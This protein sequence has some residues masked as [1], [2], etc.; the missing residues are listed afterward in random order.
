MRAAP[1]AERHNRGDPTVS[2][3]VRPLLQQPADGGSRGVEHR[4]HATRSTA[5]SST[6]WP[7]P[8]ACGCC[9]P[10]ARSSRAATS[11]TSTPTRRQKGFL[12]TLFTN[13]TLIT[14]RIADYLAVW[15]PFAIEITL[16]GRTKETYERLTGIPGSYEK[17][18]RGIDLLLERK[19]P[20]ALKTVAVTINM[21]ELHDMQAF[22]DEL[23][24]AFKFDGMMNPRDR[25]LAEPAR[26]PADA[27]GVRGA[28]SRGST[29][30]RRVEAHRQRSTT[31]PANPA[32]PRRRGLPLWRRRH[33]VCH[34]SAR[35]P[36]HLRALAG[37][38]SS[39]CEPDRCAT[40]G[41]ARC[42][43]CGR[44]RSGRP[45]KCTIVRAEVV[46]VRDVS[47]QRRA[48][49]RRS[50]SARRFSVPGRAP[51]R[52]RASTCPSRRTATAS[53][54]KGGSRVRRDDALGREAQATH[55]RRGRQPPSEDVTHAGGAGRRRLRQRWVLV[56]FGAL[57]ACGPSAVRLRQG[58]GGTSAQ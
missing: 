18:L 46:D 22:A 6:S 36:Q 1:A 25:L 24:V 2:A 31:G 7:M 44:A 27:R 4:A 49:E 54:A 53:T 9:S 16:Y 12:I 43:R 23:G 55:T 33:V 28:R 47:R 52:L 40:A 17:C 37:R 26:G 11:S 29:P 56:L 14:P 30:G 48:G 8:D 50:R 3:H 57:S 32:G 34:R 45:T 5:G 13:G 51:A 15:R 35:R 42:A 39:A 20:L 19:L 41:T 38:T 58:F 21:H 10:A